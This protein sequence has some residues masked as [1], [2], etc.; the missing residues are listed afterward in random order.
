MIMGSDY[1]IWRRIK[2]IPFTVTIP[3]KLQNPELP[4]ELKMELPGIL[5]WA[6]EGCFEW[7][8]IGIQE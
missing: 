1:A 3:E 7:Q 4:A 8:E 6:V 2:V 5:R